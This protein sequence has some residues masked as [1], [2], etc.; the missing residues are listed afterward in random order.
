DYI[1]RCFAWRIFSQ[2]M[3]KNLSLEY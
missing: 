2:F 1:N 3:C